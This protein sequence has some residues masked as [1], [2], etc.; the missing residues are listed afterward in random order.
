GIRVQPAAYQAAVAAFRGRKTKVLCACR[1]ENQSRQRQQI[2][3]EHQ[4]K[5][6]AI[7]AT[8]T[9]TAV[10]A[11]AIMSSAMMPRPP[12]RFC[13]REMGHG[14]T[15]SKKRKPTNVAA[16]AI[17]LKNGPTGGIAGLISGI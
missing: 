3:G 12:S 16:S 6:F 17:G 10:T 2:C 13:K 7:A 1:L 11:P 5:A 4:P 8:K 15:M 9:R 14:F